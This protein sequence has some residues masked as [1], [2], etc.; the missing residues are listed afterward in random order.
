[1]RDRKHPAG[2][3]LPQVADVEI[4]TAAPD[5]ASPLQDSCDLEEGLKS[6]AS[7]AKNALQGRV[8]ALVCGHAICAASLLVINKW[9]LKHFPYVWT[10]A[11]AQ[12][13]FAAICIYTAG[14]LGV[15]EVDALQIDKLVKFFPAAGMFFITV[16]AGNA[17][18]GVS[19]VDTFI[20]MR[21]VVPIP[22]A[23]L[24][25]IALG[26]PCP[27][28]P[29]WI[30]LSTILL[31]AISYCSA[32]QGIVVGSLAWVGLY[33]TLMPLD[34]VLIKHVAQQS[35][36]TPWGLVL[37]NNI[38]A[39]GPGLLFALMIDTE[40][41]LMPG[42]AMSYCK[43]SVLLPCLLSCCAGVAIS[44]FQMNVRK[45]ISSTAFMVLGVSNKFLSVLI[46]QVANLDA[47]RDVFSLG[48]VLLSISGAILFQQT[49]SGKG[50]SQAPTSQG[51]S[52][53][54]STKGYILLSLALLAAAYISLHQASKA[55]GASTGEPSL[56]PKRA[57]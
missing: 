6:P 30:G 55:L 31:G 29:S 14:K 34:G 10:L 25:A 48:S 21:S 33:L 42:K 26:E 20:V 50:V 24:E 46:N 51:D 39:A 16:A 35:G 36:L 28:P 3:E 15:L 2:I 7:K 45:V 13:V 22:T 18:V 40:L 11:M 49:V 52:K 5:A 4:S 44:F 17:V 8:F 1:M 19:N 38:C 9:A 37:Y 56:A 32:N 53:G 27:P 41:L 54:G 12:F 57:G 23:M 43:F 47:N